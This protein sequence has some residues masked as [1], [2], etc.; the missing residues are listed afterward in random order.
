MISAWLS[1]LT[2]DPRLQAL[3]V[4]FASW[5]VA[6]LTE[7]LFRS[8]LLIFVQN[9]KTQ[10]DDVIVAAVRRPLFLS[11]LFLGVSTAAAL[12]DPKM[13]LVFVLHA[14]LLTLTVLLWTGALMRIATAVLRHLSQS[15]RPGTVLQ[16]RTMP[17]FEML[18]K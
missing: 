3:L 13:W 9:T 8:I 1:V 5:I 10:L 11:V 2:T 18:A 7:V 15:A 14:T 12:L 6:F 4:L 17:L 16:P